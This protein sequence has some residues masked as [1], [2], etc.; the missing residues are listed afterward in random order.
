MG[1][2]N[3][4]LSLVS[5]ADLSSSERLI[6]A[7][8]SSGKAALATAA[9]DQIIGVLVEGGTASGDTVAVQDYGTAWVKLGG[10]VGEGDWLTAN[11]ASKAVA[12]TTAA[13]SVLGMALTAGVA[14]DQITVRLHIG[15]TPA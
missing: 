4:T 11:S 3:D 5:A 2:V 14:N 8:D 6:V 13:D 9:T 10:T 1:N 15:G 12:T 7:I